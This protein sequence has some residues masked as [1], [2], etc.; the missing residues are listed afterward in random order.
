MH[1]RD[2]SVDLVHDPQQRQR[3]RVVAPDGH[4]L[5]AGSHDGACAFVDLMNRLGD[6]ERVASEVSGIGNLLHCKGFHVLD[7]VIC[8]QQLGRGTHMARSEACAR[9]IA[10]AGVEGHADD[11]H[12]GPGDFVDPGQTS[13]GGRPAIPRDDQAIHRTSVG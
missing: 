3:D 4:Q 9:P 6:V 10:H 5:G 13:E 8:A 2:R 12:V 11:R 1:H 7:R